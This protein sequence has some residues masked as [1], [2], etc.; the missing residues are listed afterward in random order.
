M[1]GMFMCQTLRRLNSFK[2]DNNEL[3]VVN[4]FADTHYDKE[5]PINIESILNKLNITFNTTNFNNSEQILKESKIREGILAKVTR[6]NDTIVISLNQN[7]QSEHRKRFTLAHELAHCILHAKDIGEEGGFVDFFRLDVSTEKMKKEDLP[8][9]YDEDLEIEANILAGAILMPQN[10]LE[11]LFNT[12]SSS[13]DLI[14]VFQDLSQIFNVSIAVVKERLKYLN[15]LN[16]NY[17]INT[18]E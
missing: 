2:E 8:P 7:I 10:V 18:N 17:E 5:L 1:G 9:E 6:N 12:L 13:Y 14:Q 15:L 11:P 16:T 4:L 3:T